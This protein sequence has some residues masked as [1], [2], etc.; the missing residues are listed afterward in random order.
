MAI[1]CRSENCRRP[2]PRELQWHMLLAC[3]P[4]QVIELFTGKFDALDC[5]HCAASGTIEPSLVGFFL[6]DRTILVLDRGFDPVPATLEALQSLQQAI[7]IELET[8][9]AADLDEFKSLF[10]AHVKSV[11]KLYPYPDFESRDI[12]MNASNWRGLQ[13]EVLTSLF[14]GAFGIVPK[15]GV[16]ARTVEGAPVPPSETVEVLKAKVVELATTWPAVLPRLAAKNRLEEVLI[17]LVDTC[18]PMAY[19]ADRIVENARAMNEAVD[20]ADP[21]RKEFWP[22]LLTE[23]FQASVYAALGRENPEAAQWAY[24]YLIAHVA[25]ALDEQEDKPVFPLISLRRAQTTMPMEAASAAIATI[26]QSFFAE[27]PFSLETCQEKVD[28]L[29]A[30]T[31]SIGQAGL[32]DQ[33]LER[34]FKSSIATRPGPDES[35]SNRHHS[36]E[37]LAKFVLDFEASDPLADAVAALGYFRLPWFDDGPCLER[38][39]DLLE[40]S[41]IACPDKRARLLAWFGERLKLAGDPNTVLRRIGPVPQDWEDQLSP[42]GKRRLWTERSN[43]LRLTGDSR[44]ALDV[45][46]TVLEIAT[47]DEDCSA[48]D[49][50]TAWTNCGILFRENGYFEDAVRC[51]LK[52][53]ELAPPGS[54]WLQAQ[55]LVVT[56][57]RM[58]RM[59]K[60][61]ALIE[62][63][64]KGMVGV[65]EADMRTG[66]MV[67]EI[68]LRLRVGQRA[69]AL[70]LL[71]QCPPPEALPIQALPSYATV[72]RLL[73]LNPADGDDR[74][75][76]VLTTLDRLDAAAGAFEAKGNLMQAQALSRAAAVLAQDFELPDAAALWRRDADLSLKAGR[77]P[78]PATAIEIA[79]LQIKEDP[80]TFPE[81]V[82]V[83]PAA[84]AAHAGGIAVDVETFHLLSPLTD[85][86]ERLARTALEA[87]V[88]PAGLQIL[89]ELRR[90]AHR[91]AQ[92]RHGERPIGSGMEC[93]QT[94]PA[95]APAFA[96][97]EWCDVPGATMGLVTMVAPGEASLGFLD[98][99]ESF[100]L[101]EFAAR[102][103][104]RIDNWR[105]SRPGE[106]H[107][108]D[109]WPAFETWLTE[110]AEDLFPE[111]GHIVI[112]DHSSL[113]AL[114]FH[115]ALKRPWSVSYATDWLAIEEAVRANGSA[116][117]KARIGLLHS[118]RDNETEAVRAALAS[119]AEATVELAGRLDLEI[120]YA[121]PGQADAPAL[122]RL[123]ATTDILK[124]LCHGQVSLD[125][126]EVALVVDHD[127]RAPPG[128]SFGLALE[129]TRAHRFG[130]N[131]LAGQAAGSRTIF[132]GA[133]SSG[134]VSVI[135]LDERTSIASSLTAAGTSTIVAPRCKI[136]AELALPVLDDILSRFVQG[137]PLVEAVAAAAAAAEAR[138]VPSWQSAAFVIEGAWQ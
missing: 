4:Q 105:I 29:R 93:A 114:P 128:N 133:C 13:G 1:R 57:V 115:M 98:L 126:S 36:P 96:V 88:G 61:A 5:P 85:P 75:A 138:G 132:L 70:A 118:T 137:T 64:R 97:I 49:R 104:A 134:A 10:A 43:A 95:Q 113:V 73:S 102:V 12:D 7:D 117:T 6:V 27:R 50:A 32:V 21:E 109:D 44:A 2:A 124:V 33:I 78:D 87:G 47:E 94:M 111:G 130:R 55:A 8:I 112:I 48:G 11:A 76:A 116:V 127:G 83:L 41:M 17:R 110:L 34:S 28:A 123:L 125:G 121:G 52:G 81:A 72:L 101:G 68:A 67:T 3:Q 84:L 38:L 131:E 31:A 92:V 16:E 91:K 69:K 54:T 135:G 60:A 107:R 122:S 74:E 23:G 77:L 22:R 71:A 39:V 79:I 30:A 80:E 103:E 51:L 40:P 20:Q 46:I 59:G 45:A 19:V 24:D 15:F 62:D 129:G 58:G 108:T 56:Y 25:A 89:A 63:A 66:L 42:V 100:D 35:G 53:V 65:D 82:A 99:P 9:H 120:D 136:D 119:S 90:N 26:L 37:E 106:P 18:G 14:V 86:F